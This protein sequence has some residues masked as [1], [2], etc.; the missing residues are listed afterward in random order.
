VYIYIARE[1]ERAG[2][3]GGGILARRRGRGR[4]STVIETFH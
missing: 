2:R 4:A 1:R 3:R